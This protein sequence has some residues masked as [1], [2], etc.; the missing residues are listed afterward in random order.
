[1]GIVYNSSLVTDELNKVSVI[2]P[3]IMTYLTCLLNKYHGISKSEKYYDILVGNWIDFFIHSVCLSLL[4]G[5]KQISKKLQIPIVATLEEFDE[6]RLQGDW[7]DHLR[8]AIPLLCNNEI[9][10]KWIFETKKIF[11][12]SGRTSFKSKLLKFIGSKEP[13][14]VM[15]SPCIKDSKINTLKAFWSW[16]KFLALETYKIDVNF[17]CDV[18]VNWRNCHSIN[19]DLNCGLEK[20]VKSLIPLYIPVY[21]LEGF[22]HYRSTVLG[23]FNHRPKALYSAGALYD[24]TTFKLLAAEWQERGT[25]LLYHQ[26]GGN[27]GTDLSFFQE[28]YEIRVSD[29]YYTFGWGKGEVVRS[30]SASIPQVK[31][32]IDG[33][34]LLMCNN[35]PKYPYKLS[36]TPMP[37]TIEKKNQDTIEFVKKIKNKKSLFIRLYKDDYNWNLDK[38]IANIDKNLV[39]DNYKKTGFERYAESRLVVHDYLGTSY[40]E[41]LALNIPTICFYDAESAYCFRDE[42]RPYI[43]ELEDAGI[44][45]RTAESAAEFVNKIENSPECWWSSIKVQ[46]A[47]YN[48]CEQYANFSPNWANLWKEEFE[49]VLSLDV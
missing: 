22:C 8:C 31:R 47:R 32:K 15:V 43:S 26:H 17:S 30:L 2:R 19:M 25:L 5:D 44:L 20:I 16:R 48:F 7:L 1:M 14:I 34:I 33:F 29:F 6:L 41:T 40:L 18:D 42:A 37:G 28:E 12:C 45:H 39:F 11:I 38:N 24:N 13:G 36:Y 35:Y 3:V 23:N 46:E 9:S 27:Y 21:M 49:R 4:E 10:E